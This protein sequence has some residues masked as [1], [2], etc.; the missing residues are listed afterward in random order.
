MRFKKLLLTL[1]ILIV[2]LAMTNVVNAAETTFAVE[3]SYLEVG[4]P[5]DTF[6][7][8]VTI[9]EAT[10]VWAWSCK[11]SWNSSVVNCTE[12]EVGPFNPPGTSLIAYIDNEKGEIGKLASYQLAEETVSGSGVVAIL[13]F[14]ATEVGPVNLNISDANYKIEGPK[15]TKT[16]V[17]QDQIQQ[18]EIIV[19][20]EFPMFLI[21]PLFLIITTAVAVMAKIGRSRKSQH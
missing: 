6:T 4:A 5:G 18:A 14:V 20:P 13:T 12:K 8:N 7:I 1:S 21:L 10:D 16:T 2:C 11:V 19:I 17:P 9:S 3:P 15:G